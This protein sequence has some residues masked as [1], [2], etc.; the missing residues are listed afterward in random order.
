MKGHT[1]INLATKPARK[2][3]SEQQQHCRASFPAISIHRGEVGTW[4]VPR[5]LQTGIERSKKAQYLATPVSAALLPMAA[6]PMSSTWSV[7]VACPA[8]KPL[9]ELRAADRPACT[10]PTMLLPAPPPMLPAM[11]LPKLA[12]A[13]SA[14]LTCSHVWTAAGQTSVPTLHEISRAVSVHG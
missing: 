1:F 2:Q 13:D 10:M 8:V 11:A 6:L 12:I 14:W 9:P 4:N 3:P 7:S 5:H